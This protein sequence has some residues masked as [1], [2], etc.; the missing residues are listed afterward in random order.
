MLHRFYSCVPCVAA[1]TFAYLLFFASPM[2]DYVTGQMLLVDGGVAQKF[3][4]G[5]PG[6]DVSEAHQ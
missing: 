5:A 2:A 6:A 4:L 3:P 1:A